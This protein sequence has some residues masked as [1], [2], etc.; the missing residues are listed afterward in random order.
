MDQSQTITETKPTEMSVEQVLHELE[1]EV[2]RALTT[3]C[4]HRQ[5]VK[6]TT[7]EEKIKFYKEVIDNLDQMC[8]ASEI[9]ISHLE[10][11]YPD[12]LCEESD[13]GSDSDSEPHVTKLVRERKQKEKKALVPKAK[14]TFVLTAGKAKGQT[15]KSNALKDSNRCSKHK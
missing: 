6:Y 4:N 7:D 2:S 10:S 11:Q 14:C 13:E 8:E 1:F 15:C 5:S 12:E 9:V 3:L